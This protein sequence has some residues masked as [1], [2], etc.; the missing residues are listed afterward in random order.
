MYW[1]SDVIN[2][3]IIREVCDWYA[4]YVETQPPDGSISLAVFTIFNTRHSHMLF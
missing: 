1:K 3:M 4:M 2:R